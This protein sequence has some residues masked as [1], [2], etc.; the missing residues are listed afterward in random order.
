MCVFYVCV[1]VCA[2]VCG[3]GCVCV[4]YVCTFIEGTF[5]TILPLKLKWPELRE[6]EN[7]KTIAK[8]I[9]EEA[10]ANMNCPG[11]IDEELLELK[12]PRV[13]KYARTIC[14]ESERRR[15]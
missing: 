9:Q 5:Q 4:C 1:Y 11:G 13:F 14:K 10:K 6:H 8:K 7:Y 15:S 2:C 3:C 12:M